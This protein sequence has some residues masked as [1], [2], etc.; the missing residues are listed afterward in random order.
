VPVWVLLQA[1]LRF[2]P[3]LKPIYP[4]HYHPDLQVKGNDLYYGVH[5]VSPPAKIDPGD[6]VVVE[7]IVR[8]S[9]D[10]PCIELQAGEQIFLKE[11]PLT[12][13]E[14]AITRRWEHESTAKTIIELQR[15]LGAPGAQ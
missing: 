11:G 2:N 10:D 12:R 9:P 1:E 14:G 6:Q 4:P 5:F 3:S 13:A 8:A 15:E 7:L